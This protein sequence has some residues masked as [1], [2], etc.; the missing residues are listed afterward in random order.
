VGD[1]VGVVLGSG[2]A[3]ATC[4]FE[5]A[6]AAIAK[7]ALPAKWSRRRRLT[8]FG[9][10][11]DW[12]GGRAAMEVTITMWPPVAELFALLEDPKGIAMVRYLLVSLRQ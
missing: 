6:P 10:S 9:P 1:G 5:Q 4:L 12:S 2:E 7:P 8:K 11:S 3:L